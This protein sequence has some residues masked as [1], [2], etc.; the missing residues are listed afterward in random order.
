MEGNRA[1]LN[2]RRVTLY[3]DSLETKRTLE[4]EAAKHGFG[5]VSEYCQVLMERARNPPRQD[6]ALQERMT[7]LE[8]QVAESSRRLVEA[9]AREEALLRQLLDAR[10]RATEGVL[11]AVSEPVDAL[12]VQVFRDAR[13]PDGTFRCVTKDELLRAKRIGP[14]DAA[15]RARL[16]RQVRYL[17]DMELARKVKGREA[18]V[19]L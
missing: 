4:A 1:A 2:Q 16:E 14:E 3:L 7:S 12:V 9:T 10:D 5:S 17:C 6:H 18:W 11:D 13:N 8:A 19:W 15:A